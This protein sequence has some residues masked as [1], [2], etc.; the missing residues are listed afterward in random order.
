[1]VRLP[2]A[3]RAPLTLVLAG[4]C[5]LA[6]CSL[7]PTYER[8]P[9]P[10]QAVWTTRPSPST[11]AV[12]VAAD[13]WQRFDSPELDTLMAEALA[14][15]EDIAAAI[16]RIDQARANTRIAGAPLLPNVEATGSTSGTL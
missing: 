16:A 7:V 13:W 3:R 12:P 2:S 5:V 11:A 14:A 8:P 10:T 1:M 4:A 9:V 6:G 15:N